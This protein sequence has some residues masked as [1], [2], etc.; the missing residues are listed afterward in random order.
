M[1]PDLLEQLRDIHLPAD[2]SWWPPA[3]GWWLLALVAIAGLVYLVHLGRLAWRRRRP[4][5]AA[6]HLYAAI[7]TEYA[8]GTLTDADYLHRTNELLKRLVIHGLG[9]A[10]ARSANDTRWLELLDGLAGTREFSSGPGV[11][12]GN[13]RFG[14][15]PCAEVDALHALVEK[16]LR[17]VRP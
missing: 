8:Q 12:L 10:G 3:P 13:Q 7:H 14:P 2:P 1:Q 9:N 16:F 4:L 17:E 5:K 15:R 6:R 11:A